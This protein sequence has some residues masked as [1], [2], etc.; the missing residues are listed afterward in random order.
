VKFARE[1]IGERVL[2]SNGLTSL[3]DV[4][5]LL[6]V[7]FV[8]TARFGDAEGRLRTDVQPAAPGA[9]AAALQPVV[10]RVIGSGSGELFV[11]GERTLPNARALTELLATLP[12]GSGIV[13]TAQATAR[14]DGIAA[15]LQAASDAG[16]EDR[17]YQPD[18]TP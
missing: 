13:V 6:L 11:V 8:L 10:V 12:R 18:A 2:A 4:V 9:S 15:A 1:R 7:F 3:I 14:V 5:F 16:F 17:S